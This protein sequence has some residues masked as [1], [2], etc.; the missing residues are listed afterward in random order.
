MLSALG[1]ITMQQASPTANTMHKIKQLLDYAATHLEAAVNYRS[2]NRVLVAHSD[3]SYLSDTKSRS[4][5]GGH[6][7]RARDNAV[8]ENNGAV[9]TVTQ[10]IKTVMSSA[11]EVE[12]GALYFNCREAIPEWHL[13]EA[14]DIVN[15][16][17]QC[18][19]TT[20]PRWV[21]SLTVT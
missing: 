13:L 19:P 10:I 5:A 15:L 11:A 1:S 6:F 12:L 14:M 2:I 9:H 18:K 21:S 7:F 20:P 3:A 17:P 4:R 16:Q 8:P